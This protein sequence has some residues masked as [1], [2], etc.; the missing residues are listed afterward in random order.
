MSDD[1]SP[2]NPRIRAS[3]FQRETIANALRFALD[4]GQLDF[5]EYDTR[6]RTA[7]ASTYRDELPVL[8]ADLDLGPNLPAPTH[9]DFLG[10]VSQRFSQPVSPE[11]ME[12]THHPQQQETLPAT[13]PSSEVTSPIDHRALLAQAGAAL[14]NRTISLLSEHSR[15]GQF[16]LANNHQVLSVFSASKIDLTSAT[17]E[18]LQSTIRINCHFGEVEL[19]VP[20]YFRIVESVTAILGEVRIK[21]KGQSRH[22]Q[23][24]AP[25]APTLTLTGLCVFSSVTIYRVPVY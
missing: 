6:S 9:G 13:R 4:D 14:Q 12:T 11:D 8:V 20:D 5:Q 10:A 24:L 7:R 2:T 15:K 21:D 25:D 1:L 18:S 22:L 16:T 19:V 17:L 23:Q 3:G